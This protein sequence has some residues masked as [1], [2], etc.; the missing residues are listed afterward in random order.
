MKHLNQSKKYSQYYEAI[1][2]L[3][4]L[5]NIVNSYQKFNLKSHQQPFVFLER[6]QDFLNEIGNPEHGFKYIHITGTAGKGSVAHLVHGAL[7]KAGKKSGIF[8]SPFT[9][10]TIEKIQVGDKYIDPLVFAEITEDLKPHIDR[11]ILSGR[12]GGP[13]YFETMFAIAL[14]YFKKE[15][16]EYVIL[17][18]GLGGHYD[19]TN[20]IKNPLVTTITNIGLDHTHIL[21]IHRDQIAKDKS[22]IIKKGSAFFTT[23]EDPKILRIFKKQCHAVKA[24]YCALEVGGLDY[25]SRNQLLAESIFVSLG[26]ISSVNNVKADMLLPARFEIVET[27]PFVIIDGAH[28]PSKIQ[29]TVYNLGKLKYKNLILIIAVSSD[30]DWKTM[31]KLLIPNAHIV[32]VTRFSIPGRQCVDP[33]LL[34]QEANKYLR[35]RGLVHLYSDP[36]QAYDAARKELGKY[37]ALLVTGSFYIAGDVRKLFCSEEKI[38]RQ[39]NSK[40]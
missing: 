20:I 1:D 34:F 22:G 21:G 6:M 23:E 18:V 26:V 19:A 14:L 4:S 5:S 7:L 37:D 8:T 38:L 36:L 2:Y 15:K 35:G 10:S 12:H 39:R 24:S 29:S 27:S 16:C 25:D 9:I 28:N 32:Y 30:K 3:E 31:I 11:M 40:I 33:R 13:S 17:E